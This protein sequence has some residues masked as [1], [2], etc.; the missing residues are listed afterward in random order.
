MKTKTR[1]IS[2]VSLV[3]LVLVPTNAAFAQGPGPAEGKVIF[4]SNFTLESGDTFT[5]DLVVFGGNVTVEK[6]A[7]LNG[8]LVV[9]G[10]RVGSDG[11]VAGDVV[12][13]GG[14]V[15][16]DEH[17]KVTGDVVTIGG[18]LEKS[19]GAVIEGD[20][21]NNVQPDITFPSG[22]LPSNG[23]TPPALNFDFGFNL[24]A[25]IFKVFFLAVVAAGFA[26]LLSL[27]WQPQMERAG[28]AVVSQPLMAGAIGLLAVLIGLLLVLTIIPPIVVGFAWLFGMMALGLEVGQR[29][30]TAINQSWSPVLTVGLGTFLLVL[31]GGAFG[32]VPCLG[33]LAQF[34]LALLAIGSVVMTRFGTRAVQS[35]VMIVNAPLPPPSQPQNP[36]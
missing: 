36:A 15:N 24:I 16:L 28:D 14:Q 12:I 1:I 30:T 29:F 21:L 19:E 17:A 26:M 11:S 25:Q 33:G 8:N 35:P 13:I 4:G 23:P 34:M 18:Q 31:V 6:D 32:F 3:L 22:K 5:G 20:V 9:F 27:F 10:G 7:D 2:L